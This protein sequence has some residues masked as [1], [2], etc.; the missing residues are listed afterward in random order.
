MN[1]IFAKRLLT[2]IAFAAAAG[3]AQVATAAGIH[4]RDAFTDGARAVEPYLDGASTGER[5]PFTDGAR[6]GERSIF[7]DGARAE[8]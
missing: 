4:D 8:A 5:N 3:A 1:T 7:T 6:T 2:V